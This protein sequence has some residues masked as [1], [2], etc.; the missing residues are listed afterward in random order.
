MCLT[1]VSLH[2]YLAIIYEPEHVL[3]PGIPEIPPVRKETRS[4]KKGEA[5]AKQAEGTTSDSPNTR[6]DQN[7]TPSEV[8]VEHNLNDDFQN[9]CTIESPGSLGTDELL[10]RSEGADIDDDDGRS[11][12]G[13]SYVSGVPDE[14]ASAPS[15]DPSTSRSSVEGTGRQNSV[16]FIPPVPEEVPD[17]TE[18]SEVP[19]PSTGVAPSHFYGKRSKGK[20]KEKAVHDV[21]VHMEDVKPDDDEVIFVEHPK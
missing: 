13:L 19:K 11:S 18:E 12:A 20:G 8:E 6:D 10:L 5:A 2:W 1:F 4:S 17:S 14:G 7:P 9:S 3:S 16:E 15:N 21:D